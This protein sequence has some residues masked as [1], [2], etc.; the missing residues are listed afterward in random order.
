MAERAVRNID[1]VVHAVDDLDEAASAYESLGFSVTP[2]ADHPFGTSNR[3][4]VLQDTYVEIVC[5]SDPKR[6]PSA[7][8]AAGVTS[9]LRERGSG[10]SHVVLSSSDPASDLAELGPLA[11]GEIFS[12]SRPAPQLDGTEVKA[13]FE[14]TFAKGTDDLGMFLCRHVAPSAV[15]N[16]SNQWHPNRALHIEE[17]TLP[18]QPSTLDTLATMART[19]AS[20]QG[21]QVG[22]AWITTGPAA[23]RF[24]TILR[25]VEIGGVRVGGGAD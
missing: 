9:R 7:G 13:S 12:F 2:R 1:H 3:L 5:V 20:D 23:I 11:T 22:N 18:V 14:C 8:F 25:P 19:Q 24:D 6:I 17:L 4:V 21:I 15:W 16:E 10:I